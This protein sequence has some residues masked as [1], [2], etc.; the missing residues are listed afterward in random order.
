MVERNFYTCCEILEI[1]PSA[2]FSE[3]T[4]AYHYLKELYTVESIVTLPIDV[5]IG[6]E[7]K[8][9]ILQQ[10][11]DS[12]KR[13]I[14]LCKHDEIMHVAYELHEKRG[15]TPGHDLEDW[16]EAEKIII[17]TYLGSKPPHK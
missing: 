6:E 14:C 13:L 2:S 5:D 7:Y 11:E 9:D 16:A 1:S 4:E 8:K 17:S 10:I 15:G 12:Y 3:I